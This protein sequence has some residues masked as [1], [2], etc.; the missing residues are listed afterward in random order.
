MAVHGLNG[1]REKTFTA[2]NGV[3]WLNSLLPE[4]MPK[5]RVFSY[6]YDARTHSSSPLS[7]DHLL[8]HAEDFLETFT[9]RRDLTEV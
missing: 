7:S 2:D 3:C 5:I 6:G 9:M 1:N 4:V 8:G